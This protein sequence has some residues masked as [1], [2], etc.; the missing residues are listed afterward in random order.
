MNRLIVKIRHIKHLKSFTLI[1]MV[2]VVLLIALLLN[3]LVPKILRA[4]DA[5]YKKKALSDI[6]VMLAALELYKVDNS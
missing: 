5:V 1:E 2:F 6:R 4:Y 3:V